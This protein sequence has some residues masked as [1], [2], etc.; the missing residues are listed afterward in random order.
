[1]AQ[2]VFIPFSGSGGGGGSPTGP[3]GGDLSGTYPNPTVAKIQNNAVSAGLPTQGQTLMWSGAAWHGAPQHYVVWRPGGVSVDDVVTTWAEVEARITATAGFITVFVDSSL[4]A[5][6]V[7]STADTE[8]Y[9]KTTFQS[10]NPNITAGSTMSIAD[11][12]RIRNLFTLKQLVISC[13]PTAVIPIRIDIAGGILIAREGGGVSLDAGATVSAVSLIGDFSEIAAFEGG[14]FQNNTGNPALA[15]INIAPAV[16][17]VLH[18][19][20][21]AAGSFLPFQPAYGP[22]LFSGGNAGTTIL[23]IYDSS[24]PPVVQTNYLGLYQPLAMSNGVGTAYDDSTVPIPS[25]GVANVQ[26]AIDVLKVQV[27]ALIPGSY[28]RSFT[29]ADLVVGILTVV[30]NLGV[31]YNTWAIYD[32]NNFAVLNPDNAFDVDGNTLDFDL[33]TYQLVNGGAIPGTWN[34][35]VQS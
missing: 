27:A 12:G 7:P 29:D 1:M 32:N 20:I 18:A 4:G 33:S 28:R 26:A 17:N 19:V 6:I 5:A 9:G 16:A 15:V 13:A 23:Q 22:T 35:V 14:S 30:H 8:C 34:V 31:R 25:L 10:F 21:S 24:A 2:L 3:A 11:G